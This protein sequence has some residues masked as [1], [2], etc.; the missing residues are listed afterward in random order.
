VFT[1]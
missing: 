1:K